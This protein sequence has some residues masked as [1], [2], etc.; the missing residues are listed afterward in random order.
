MTATR[1]PT[2][3]TVVVTLGAEWDRTRECLVSL[4]PTLRPC[5]QVIAVANGLS[6]R[7]E[8]ELAGHSWLEVIRG[9]AAGGPVGRNRAAGAA[10]GEVTVFLGEG[11]LVAE[12]WLEE[13]LSP[14]AD[15]QVGAVGPRLNVAVAPQLVDDAQRRIATLSSR[16]EFAREWAAAHAGRLEEAHRLG[17]TCLAVR[18]GLFRSLEGFDEGY[19]TS[20]YEDDD[21]CMRLRTGGYRLVV[22]HGCYVHQSRVPVRAQEAQATSLDQLRFRTAWGTDHVAPLRLLSVCLIVKDEERLLPACLAS[23]A[24]IADE[25]IVYDTG[26]SDRTVE[27]A[28]SAGARVIEGYWDDSFA[29]ARNAALAQAVGE[30]VFS[31]D[32]DEVLL[33]DPGSLRAIVGDRRSKIEAYLVSIEN[34]HGAG[35]ARSVHTAIRL[36]RRTHCTWRHRLHEQVVAAD[37]SS[38]PLSIGYLSGSR[39]VHYGYAAD[40]F[41]EKGKAERN[42]ALAR[43]ALD[44]EGVS[45]AYALMN[46]GRALESAGRSDESVTTLYE[47]AQVAVDPITQRMAVKNLIHILA[48]LR[49]FDEALAQVA[50]LRRISSS[51]IAADTAEG[52]VRISMGD[53]QLGLSLLDRVPPRG[54]DDEGMEYA[55]HTLAA[56]RG[57]A[58]ASLGRFGEAADVVLAT[59][60]SDGVLEADLGELTLWLVK[61]QR[62]PSEI[63]AALDVADL[64]PVLGRV[65][66]QPVPLADI[67]LE[68]IWERFA[69]RLEPL[70]AAGRL[71]PRLP[72]ARALV[73]SSRLRHHG[74]RAACPL[75]AIAN[76]PNADQHNRLLAA[77]AAFGA[78][79]EHA[80]VRAA[81][82]AVGHL[83]AEVREQVLDEVARIAPGL[84]EAEHE[85][86][87]A[88]ATPDPAPSEQ[89]VL[90]GRSLERVAA[91]LVIAASVRR[92]GLNIVGPFENEDFYG[93]TARGVATWLEGS[94]VAVSTTTYQADGRAGP[95]GWA[96]LGTGD[97]PY[98]TTL[99]VLSPEDVANFVIDNGAAAFEDRYMIA[100][101]SWD[102]PSPSLVMGSSARMVHEIWVPSGFTREVVRGVTDRPVTQMWLPTAIDESGDTGVSAS[103][104]PWFLASVDFSSGMDRQN[105]HGVLEAFCR[106]FSPGEGPRLTLVTRRADHYLAERAR[107]AALVEARDDITLVDGG[108]DAQRRLFEG[109]AASQTCYVELHRSEGTGLVLARAM[110]SGIVTIATRWSLAAEVHGPDDYFSI[111]HSMEPVSALEHRCVAG[112]RWAEP[113][114]DAA[115]S[116]MRTVVEQPALA[117]AM[118]ARAQ[119][120][121]RRRLTP[122][123][124]VRAMSERLATIDR[125]RH[126]G[127]PVR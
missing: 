2:S 59:V 99:L 115:A 93:E 23:V 89:R 117:H 15:P 78:F 38:R 34:L 124:A 56:M 14:F 31:L 76:D 8:A 32:A 70:A 127:A 43:T 118:A 63:A 107:L 94:G 42:L 27:I 62:S 33:A 116:A 97:C 37:D 120:R 84:L 71:G 21:L 35:N 41:Q 82:D 25:V 57:E 22:S 69:D 29:R 87:D 30:W 66:R 36:F 80:V 102:L 51:Q 45:K 91:P 110:L 113:D 83:E 55:A 52:I 49:R 125:L 122:G 16:E 3:A 101:W 75:V 39:I 73:W 77:A 46:Y 1:H 109:R 53:A 65:L 123:F 9:E 4:A 92:G 68:G 104:P 119:A 103:G 60:R 64:I 112:A 17:G 114:L 40:V 67:V 6:E 79:D 10:G 88:S 95:C 47:A 61:A 12:G 24:D 54:R 20:A 100:L 98:D 44:D 5:D 105:P 48:R 121:A 126:R 81:R 106:A 28:R 86:L 26:S 19:A 111:A 72:I 96:Q 13:L 108:A 50:Q 90:R 58:L 18:T 74:L 11:A 85:D 7:A